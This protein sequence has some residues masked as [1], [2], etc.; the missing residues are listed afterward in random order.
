MD[1]DGGDRRAALMR[2]GQLRI[3]IGANLEAMF[4]YGR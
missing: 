3:Q 4:F 1:D 2:A